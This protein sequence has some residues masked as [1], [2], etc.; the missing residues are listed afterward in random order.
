MAETMALCISCKGCKR[1]CPTGVDMARMKIE[2]LHQRRQRHG[3][4]L[5]DRV[6]GYLPRYAP[7]AA[8]AAPLM[9]LRDRIPALAR[10]SEALL[11]LSARRPLP[12][13]AREPYREPASPSAALRSVVLLVDTFTR[14]FEPENARA[15][16]RV[17]SRGGYAVGGATPKGQRPLCCGRTF[18]A[19]GLVAEAKAEARRLL[20]ALEHFVGLGVPIVGLEPSCLLTLRDELPALLPGPASTALARQARL[21]EEFVAAESAAGRWKLDIKPAPGKALLHGHC[22]QKAFDTVGASVAALKLVPGLDV[23]TFDSTCC[24]M[25]G[26]FGYEAEHYDVSLKIGELGVLPKMRAADAATVLAA[27]GTSCRHQIRDGAAREALHVSR[28][29]DQA[30][31]E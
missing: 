11:G 1:E 13:W 15:A 3:L 23:E 14:W 22:H 29:L 8:R 7:L 26:A 25:A 4:S 31:A 9:G 6:V 21:F 17:L 18:L 12:L 30:T 20:E 10:W 16:A 5:R 24:G 28:I 2:F 27:S 19:A